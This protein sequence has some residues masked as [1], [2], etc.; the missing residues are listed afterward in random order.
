MKRKMNDLKKSFDARQYEEKVWCLIGMIAFAILANARNIHDV[1]H[2]ILDT[3][4]SV[5]GFW[6][7]V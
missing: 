4:A 6:K 5:H 7:G 2:Q 1:E 3:E